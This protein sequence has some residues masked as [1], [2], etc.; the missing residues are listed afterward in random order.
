MLLEKWSRIDLL[1]ARV[2][3]RSTK[4]QKRNKTRCV[5]TCVSYLPK[6]LLLLIGRFCDISVAFGAGFIL[7]AFMVDIVLWPPHAKS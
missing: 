7:D 1:D 6:S 5:C 3:H 4:N 2:T